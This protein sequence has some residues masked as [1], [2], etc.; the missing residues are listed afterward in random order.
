MAKKINIALIGYGYWGKIVE[1]YLIQNTKY[2]LIVVHK[3]K[4]ED[5]SYIAN[6]ND[7]EA[8]YIATPI[9]THYELVTFFLNANKHILCEKPLSTS[10][11]EVKELEDLSKQHNKIIETNY[12]YLVSDS[13]K[14]LKNLLLEVGNINYIKGSITQFDKLK[15]GEDVLSVLGCHFFAVLFFLFDDKNYSSSITNYTKNSNGDINRANA[16]CDFKEFI[17]DLYFSLSDLEKERKLTIY[18]SAGILQF[19]MMNDKTLILQR[20]NS[21][22][23]IGEKIEYSFDESNNINKSLDKFLENITN[24][25]C[26]LNISKSVTAV[27]NKLEQ[28][29]KKSR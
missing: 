23:T 18:G 28:D 26:N 6:N 2:N 5:L 8:V 1:K 27:L 21:D 24:N 9:S 25:R 14:Q 15:K 20:I 12:I 11:S 19:N 10:L 4:E 13:I 17:C 3:N 22:E 16:S 29:V 7:I